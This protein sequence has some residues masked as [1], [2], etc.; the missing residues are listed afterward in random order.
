[1]FQNKPT[2]LLQRS[3]TDYNNKSL[4]NM[5]GNWTY[6]DEWDS[7]KININLKKIPHTYAS[8]GK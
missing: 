2:A 4:S 5:K 7:I 8:M 6:E 1:L 3:S